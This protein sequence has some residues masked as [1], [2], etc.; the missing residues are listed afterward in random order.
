MQVE[1]EIGTLIID[2][3]DDCDD[4]GVVVEI[5]DSLY[6]AYSFYKVYWTCQREP[7]GRDYTIT[8]AYTQEEIDCDA[9]GVFEVIG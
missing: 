9:F 5:G 8:L 7:E 6:G 4:I 2:K 1:L 3:S